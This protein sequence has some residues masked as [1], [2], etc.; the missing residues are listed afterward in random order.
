MKALIT[1]GAG[2]I[3]SHLTEALLDR[4]DDVY[5]IDDLST[6]SFENIAQYKGFK[7][8]DYIIDS[9]HDRRILAEWVD[10]ADVI[11]HLAAAVGVRLIIESPVHT[12]E[13]NIN[14]TENVLK[15]AALKKKR[16]II[17][18]TSEVYGKLDKVPFSENDDLI[19]GSTTIN[20]WSYACSKAID[21]FLSL[22][23]YREKNLPVIICRLFNTV[24]PRQ[25]GRYGMVVPT[26]INQALRGETITVFG[27]GTQTRCFGHVTDI[28][29]AL[30]KLS[31][32][33]EA[34][35]QIYNVGNSEEISIMDLAELI[36]EKTGSQSEIKLIPYEKAYESGFEDM[37]RRIPDLTKI[38]KAINYSPKMDIHS[39]IDSVIAYHKDTSR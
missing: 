29:D 12:I 14:G 36:K 10:R 38:K 28:V 6:G 16:V 11:F 17:T 30:I 25:T 39:I 23:Y 3:G 7:R 37:Y 31:D 18:S 21:E 22:A 26:F 32:L 1:G 33:D 15:Q 19:L 35:G 34:Y 4:G 9:I 8:F 27:D 5:I 13:T 2:F 24:G 20:R